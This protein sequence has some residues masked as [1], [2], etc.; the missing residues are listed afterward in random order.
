MEVKRD[1]M[2]RAEASVAITMHCQAKHQHNASKDGV[3]VIEEC[4][5]I[6]L[7]PG[8]MWAAEEL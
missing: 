3:I 8:W 2:L 7:I 4:M 5:V 1:K 6:G